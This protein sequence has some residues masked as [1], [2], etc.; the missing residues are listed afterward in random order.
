M[1]SRDDLVND[2][3]YKIKKK[4]S[5]IESRLFKKTRYYVIAVGK[6]SSTNEEDVS[7]V[8]AYIYYNGYICFYNTQGRAYNQQEYIKYIDFVKQAVNSNR[9]EWTDF[10]INKGQILKRDKTENIHLDN[11]LITP[12]KSK[13]RIIG[14]VSD[15]SLKLFYDFLNT[16]NE[17]YANKL[18]AL[19]DS[20]EKGVL[21][22]KVERIVKS[23]PSKKL[24][25]KDGEI[26]VRTRIEGYNYIS[27]YIKTILRSDLKNKNEIINALFSRVFFLEMHGYIGI[28]DDD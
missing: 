1:L 18:T 13:S 27:S 6:R 12:I 19:K 20:Y 21:K 16:I 23:I 14:N 11:E 9:Y 7:K 3:E 2:K 22:D 24:I 17:N 8:R 10:W 15:L 25:E 26:I 5:E 4:N 28:E